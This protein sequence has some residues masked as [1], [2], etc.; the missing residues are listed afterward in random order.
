LLNKIFLLKG[1]NFQNLNRLDIYSYPEDLAKKQ[2]INFIQKIL[3]GH[4]HGEILEVCNL[5][6]LK[7]DRPDLTQKNSNRFTISTPIA[8]IIEEQNLYTIYIN[9]TILIGLIF[10]KEDN[11]YD[12][13]EIFEDLLNDLLNAENCCNFEEEMEIDSFLITLFISI[14]RFGDEI[15]DGYPKITIPPAGISVKIFLFGIDNVGKSSFVRRIK[16]GQFN[17][18]YFSPTHKF[19]IEYVQKPNGIFSIW[20][21]GGQSSFREKWLN[22]IQD[23]NIIIYMI[24]VANQIRFEEA[25]QEFWNI[26]N[27]YNFSD[28]LLLIL[29]NKVDLIKEVNPNENLQS[30][31]IRN[32]IID[33]FELEKLNQITWKFILTSV[34]TNYNIDQILNIILNSE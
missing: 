7:I 16:T 27:N 13:K 4:E 11:P 12:Y 17:D 28:T 6:N 8:Q 19:T 14:R 1:I 23:S 20:D 21:M 30:E 9:S 2:S 22:G 32:E 33:F 26:F 29:G 25:K 15:L 24:D 10:D 3:S 5:N 31:R 18:N 34:K